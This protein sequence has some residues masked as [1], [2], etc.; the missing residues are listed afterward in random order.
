VSVS[1]E[2]EKVKV[3]RFGTR[4]VGYLGVCCCVLSAGAYDDSP[5]M[6]E[7]KNDSQ[8]SAAGICT[9]RPSNSST[10]RFRIGVHAK[11]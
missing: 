2:I 1:Q 7:G 4:I 9:H 8:R 11:R 3:F 10:I 5:Y 6:V